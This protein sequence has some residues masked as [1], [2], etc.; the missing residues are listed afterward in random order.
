MGETKKVGKNKKGRFTKNNN[1]GTGRATLYR[2]EYCAELIKYVSEPP[3]KVIYETRRNNAG[4]VIQK[5][6]KIVAAGYP[7]FKGF[8]AKIGVTEK[9]LLEW[10]EK[11][12]E[13]GEAY[14][15]A[16]DMQAHL[17]LQNGLNR[18]YDPG[19]ARFLLE[20][21]HGVVA[22]TINVHEAGTGCE[23]NFRFTEPNE[24]EKTD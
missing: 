7:S 9:T 12:E 19:F 20:A 10:K 4:M 5:I 22:K 15:L 21:C 1:F 16:K 14:E 24:N 8:A 2:E 23:I 17:L 13:F 11:H 3:T 18:Q 6:P